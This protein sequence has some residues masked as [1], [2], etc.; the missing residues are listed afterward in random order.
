MKK[1]LVLPYFFDEKLKDLDY[2]SEGIL[3]ELLSLIS[4]NPKLKTTSRTTSIYLK[5]NPIHVIETKKRYNV[6]V[7]VEGNV[8]I[9]NGK[10]LIST[11][12]FDTATDDLILNT[13]FFF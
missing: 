3:E 4:S 2:L 11:R 8:K 7:V 6:N 12:M 1:I 9:K 13:Q 10:Y 5:N